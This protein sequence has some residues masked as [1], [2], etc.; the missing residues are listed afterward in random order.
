MSTPNNNDQPHPHPHP[1]PYNPLEP[2]YHPNQSLTRETCIRDRLIPAN[3][4]DCIYIP[5]IQGLNKLF[6]KWNELEKESRNLLDVWEEATLN[7]NSNVDILIV[8]KEYMLMKKREEIAHSN[9]IR[10]G[11]ILSTSLFF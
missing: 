1:Y 2:D 4:N 11:G 8:L 10:A 6:K 5:D 9:Y 3:V 7:K